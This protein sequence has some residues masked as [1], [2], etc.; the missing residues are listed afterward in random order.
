MDDDDFDSFNEMMICK[1]WKTLPYNIR[2]LLIQKINYIISG[3]MAE[4]I[5]DDRVDDYN[6][7]NNEVGSDDDNNGSK[8]S[9]RRFK[10][11]KCGCKKWRSAE[12]KSSVVDIKKPLG[13]R[14]SANLDV[15]LNKYFNSVQNHENYLSSSVTSSKSVFT[16]SEPTSAI[17]TTTTPLISTSTKLITEMNSIITIKKIPLLKINSKRKRCPRKRGFKRKLSYR[18]KKNQVDTISKI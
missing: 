12:Y 2:R 16:T 10:R 6:N 14:R 8:T 13:G 17:S 18:N 3:A 1:K 9:K 5:N 7:N 4:K 15:D 11:G